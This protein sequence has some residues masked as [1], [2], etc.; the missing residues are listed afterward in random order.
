MSLSMSGRCPAEFYCYDGS[1]GYS[2]I[3]RALLQM[4]PA[5]VGIVSATVSMLGAGL[6]LV[7]YCAFKDLRIGVA[8]KI[9]T[10]LALADVGT[11]LSLLLGIVNFLVYDCRHHSGAHTPSQEERLC[12]QFDTVCQIQAFTAIACISSSHIWT[13]ALAIHFLLATILNSTNWSE[14][15]IPLYA[16]VAWTLPI[17]I[18][19]PI[20]ITGKLGYTPTFQASCFISAEVTQHDISKVALTVEDIAVVA[21]EALSTIIIVVCYMV[22]FTYICSQVN[23]DHAVLM[24]EHVPCTVMSF[25]LS[26]IVEYVLYT[27]EN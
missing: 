10:L 4:M 9:I 21:V 22:I 16:I 15:L 13:A 5:C 14:R 1:H 11:A 12:W 19:L 7:A 20:L 2:T 25:A 8:Q 18:A 6:I 26:I 24:R 17:A 3:N 23:K 27:Y